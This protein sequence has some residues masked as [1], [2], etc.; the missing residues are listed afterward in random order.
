MKNESTE[1][2]ATIVVLVFSSV[3]SSSFVPAYAESFILAP[4]QTEITT[5]FIGGNV[6]YEVQYSVIDPVL[7]NVVVSVFG[8]DEF[9][10]LVTDRRYTPAEF[11]SIPGLTPMS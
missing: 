3:D 4:N 6:A 7:N 2:T 9:G 10:N 5:F 8:I 11:T 1:D